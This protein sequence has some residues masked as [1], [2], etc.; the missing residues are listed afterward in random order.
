MR[1]YYN[2]LRQ[3][4][5]K[6]NLE[7]ERERFYKLNRRSAVPY[8]VPWSETLRYSIERTRNKVV[9]LEN[10]STFNES[11]QSKRSISFVFPSRL[12]F[13]SRSRVFGPVKRCAHN[14]KQ[15][16]H[17]I[18]VTRIAVVTSCSAGRNRHKFNVRTVQQYTLNHPRSP[19]KGPE[20]LLEGF[21]VLMHPRSFSKSYENSYRV[22]NG[23]DKEGKLQAR[24]F[25][26]CARNLH[27]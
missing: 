14:N 17:I 19:K 3:L 18:G 1:K 7:R 10:C 22:R 9:E 12:F 5:R 24:I 20:L 4:N 16:R 25:A 8:K 23:E 13:F 2:S 15:L 27:L 11:R 21:C 26:E 6:E